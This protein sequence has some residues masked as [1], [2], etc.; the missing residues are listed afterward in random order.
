MQKETKSIITDESIKN[1][2]L[3]DIKINIPKIVFFSVFMLP[4]SIALFIFSVRDLISANTS[5]M[6]FPF[7]DI[8]YAA[9]S[10]F[11]ICITAVMLYGFL[12]KL[13]YIESGR[14]SVVTDELIR[15]AEEGSVSLSFR[16]AEYFRVFYFR[17]YGRCVLN[18]GNQS[19]FDSSTVG[20]SFYVVV[21]NSKNQPPQ[22]AYNQKIY[23]YKR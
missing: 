14:F 19:M 18:Y 10:L 9:L 22:L 13:Y 2:L 12:Y 3:F 21:F 17:N 15:M 4:I 23:E 5:G 6:N 20:D 11:F 7:M 16:R 8:F 1:E